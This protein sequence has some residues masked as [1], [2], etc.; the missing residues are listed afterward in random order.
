MVKLSE[1]EHDLDAEKEGVWEEIGDGAALLIA[2]TKTKAYAKAWMKAFEPYLELSRSGKLDDSLAQKIADELIADL[3]LK[4][5]R[6]IADIDGNPLA[7]SRETALALLGNPKL[8]WLRDRVVHVS[9]LEAR[10]RA[11]RKERALGN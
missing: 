2:S 5:W 1:L 9:E 3:V 8:G 11:T 6:G 4:G 10:F 7:Y